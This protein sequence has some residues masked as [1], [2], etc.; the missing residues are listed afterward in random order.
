[1]REGP[2][3]VIR[4]LNYSFGD[5]SLI[6]PTLYIMALFIAGL[7]VVWAGTAFWC[8]WRYEKKAEAYIKGANSK[9]ENRLLEL[10]FENIELKK[11]ILRLQYEAIGW[12]KAAEVAQLLIRR[13]DEIIHNPSR[14]EFKKEKK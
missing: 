1:M 7:L 3:F 13:V 11:E 10:K 9:R 8:N 6:M 12:R 2:E 14:I 5:F 4:W